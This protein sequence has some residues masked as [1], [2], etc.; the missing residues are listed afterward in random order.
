M[1]DGERHAAVDRAGAGP[2][3]AL[4]RVGRHPIR[5]AARTAGLHP[6][7]L[8][9]YER[10]GLLRPARTAGGMRLYSDDDIA[11]ARR[12]GEITAAGAPLAA[13]RRIVRLEDLLRM[14]MERI[15]VLDDQN[16]RLS[17]RLQQR[18]AGS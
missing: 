9:D 10:R 14:A 6:Q 4:R 8:R 7:T 17:Q 13:A 18:H 16:R 3:P 11:R 5:V 1:H 12:L 15:Q 2:R